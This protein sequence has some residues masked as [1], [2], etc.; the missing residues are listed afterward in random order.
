MQVLKLWL[1]NYQLELNEN[2]YLKDNS[3]STE[4]SIIKNSI[5]KIDKELEK[6]YSQSNRL[7]DL[8]EQGI[9]STEEFL[10]RRKVINQRIDNAERY[11]NELKSQIDRIINDEAPK[12]IPKSRVENIVD[13]YYMI[14]NPSDKNK[15][16]KELIKKAVYIKTV[17]GRWHSKPDDFELIIYPNLPEK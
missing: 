2:D 14:E 9:Y 15:V 6:L 12:K 16:L 1:K 5:N 13:L 7:H 3:R 17:S 4:L 8:L 11:K 10:E